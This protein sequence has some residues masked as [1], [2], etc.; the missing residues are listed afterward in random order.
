MRALF[1]VLFLVACTSRGELLQ[2][3]FD[4]IDEMRAEVDG[5]EADIIAA[6]SLDEV[7]GQETAHQA[8]MSDLMGEMSDT[9]SELDGCA[10]HGGMMGDGW[11]MMDEMG[12]HMDQHMVDHADHVAVS[13]CSTEESTHT[14]EMGEMLDAMHDEADGWSL[15]G[16]GRGGC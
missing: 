14:E 2:R 8:T 7:A 6:T 16:G 5:H 12:N 1:P 4:L 11:T 10:D 3:Q 9:M 15:W 13:E